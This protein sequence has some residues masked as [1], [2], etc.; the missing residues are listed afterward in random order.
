[1]RKHS[2]APNSC[3]GPIALVQSSYPLSLFMPTDQAAAGLRALAADLRRKNASVF[4]TEFDRQDAG[5][6]PALAPDHPDTDAVCLIQS[7]YALAIRLAQRRGINVDLAAAFAEGDAD[8][9]SEP[10]RQAVAA[11]H[12]FDGAVVHER[13][14][15]VMDGARITQVVPRADLPR[16]SPLTTCPR[17]PGW[18]PGSSICRSTAAETCCSTISRPPMAFAPSRRPIASSAQPACCRPSSPNPEKTMR[19]LDT[20]D[21]LAA[22]EPGILGIHLE[23]PF[24]SPEKPGVHD[25]RHMRRPTTDDVAVLT[26]PRNGV[27]LVTLAPEVVPPGFIARLAAA[28]VRV[29]LGH[30]MASYRQTVPPWRKGSPALRISSMP[31]GRWR[32]GNPDR[33]R[34][35]WK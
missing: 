22:R 13:A 21:A 19:A 16:R 14:A 11:D 4:I 31:C 25:P 30:S 18:R 9:M 35:H 34:E 6:L 26:A 23:G 5:G 15:V 29:S 32:A 24:L 17:V 20:V 2:A 10:A 12:V 8:P 27:L 33:S 28:G 3:H 1:M 7:F